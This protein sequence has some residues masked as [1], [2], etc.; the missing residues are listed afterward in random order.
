M[1][2]EEDEQKPETV[3]FNES[4]VI[5]AMI[6]KLTCILGMF[7]TQNRMSKP[8][9]PRDIK[10]EVINIIIIKIETDSMKRQVI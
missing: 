8:Y 9:K 4:N 10:R 1:M 5:G 6:D 3:V 7:S 2:K